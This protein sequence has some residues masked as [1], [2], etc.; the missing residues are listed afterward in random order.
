MEDLVRAHWSGRQS[1]QAAVW[2]F[3]PL[4]CGHAD[5]YSLQWKHI[6]V[7]PAVENSSRRENHTKTSYH[8]SLLSHWFWAY[9]TGIYPRLMMLGGS[10][11]NN[12]GWN[13][14]AAGL[15]FR[16]RSLESGLHYRNINF[17][18]RYKHSK[19]PNKS[20][21]VPRC[22]TNVENC[23]CFIYNVSSADDDCWSSEIKVS[24]TLCVV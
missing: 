6:F 3:P 1:R 24:G 11:V 8:H 5:F 9:H 21:D 18:K 12:Q 15:D 14:I 10:P 19:K 23:R 20:G 17:I 13:V 4:V 22:S 16:R 2:V 7:F